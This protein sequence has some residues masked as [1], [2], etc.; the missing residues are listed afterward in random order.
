MDLAFI[1]SLIETLEESISY[2]QH[3][4]PK[5]SRL[6]GP[7][8]DL[9]CIAALKNGFRQCFSTFSG[10]VHACHPLLHSHSPH[11]EYMADLPTIIVHRMFIVKPRYL[12]YLIHSML[13]TMQRMGQDLQGW[14]DYQSC[15]RDRNLRDRDRDLVK[16]S[17]RDRD[18]D[19]IKNS[20]TKTETQVLKFE[21]ETRD[22][23]ICA[24]FRTFWKMCRHDF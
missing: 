23:K 20:E 12:L 5:H 18:R 4:Y 7:S 14:L 21:I 11:Y 22:F 1:T 10:F 9:L 8:V 13:S 16:I 6:H 15:R 2:N 17:R 19:F 24:F 3:Q